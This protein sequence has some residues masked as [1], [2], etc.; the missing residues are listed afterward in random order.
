AWA[1]A[2]GF[3]VPTSDQWEHA[4]RAGTRTFWWWGNGVAFPGPERNA[5]GVQ[6]A[7]NTYRPEWCTTPDVYRG[8][9]GGSA[10]CGGLDGLPTTL[11]L[12]SAYFEPFAGADKEAEQFVGDCRRAFPLSGG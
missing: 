1:C 8:G 2:D 3:R 4:C 11:R 5:F 10:C 6:I 12:A 7:W 9:D